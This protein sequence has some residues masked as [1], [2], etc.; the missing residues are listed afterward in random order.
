MTIFDDDP[1]NQTPQES[2]SQLPLDRSSAHISPDAPGADPITYAPGAPSPEFTPKPS[3]PEDIRVPWSWLHFFAFLIFALASFFVVQGAF[4]FYYAPHQRLPPQE[5]E[6]YLF[7]KPQI[8]FGTTIVWY[9]MIFLF[10]YMTLSVLPGRP[11]WSTLGW[12]KLES[13]GTRRNPWAFFV[14]G[15]GLAMFVAVVSSRVHGK[16]NMPIQ[17]LFKSRTS[18]LLLMSMAVFIAPLVEETVFRGYLY[19]LFAKT[20]G[21]VPGI[22]LT[23]V[24]FGLLHGAQLAWSWGIV[25]LL[26]FVGV[27]LTTIRAHTGTVV[28]S[29]LMHLG[30]NATIAVTS[31][32]AT[33]GFQQLPPLH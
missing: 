29:F 14:G 28:A 9:A 1:L 24:L 15:F 7:S 23:G 3:L 13:A 10:L 4:I 21:I 31:L 17:E 16:E 18:A 27:V 6:Q 2:G 22:L 20:F 25:A 19:P 32:I 11:F 8:V 30:Y 5:L 12:R 33:K 26:I